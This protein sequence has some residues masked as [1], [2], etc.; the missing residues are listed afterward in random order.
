[1]VRRTYGKITDPQEA[2]EALRPAHTHVNRLAQCVRPFGP[3]YLVL[4]ALTDMMATAAFHFS[5]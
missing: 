2:F 4:H 5:A 1:M 3:E